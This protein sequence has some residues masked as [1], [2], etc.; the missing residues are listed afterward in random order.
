MAE[1][2]RISKEA[3]DLI[4]LIAFEFR[5]DPLSVQCFYPRVVDRAIQLA[6]DIRKER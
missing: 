1:K 5:T 2:E 4:L 3:R 6:D